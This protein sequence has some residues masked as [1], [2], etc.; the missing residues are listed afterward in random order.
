[1]GFKPWCKLS[2]LVLAGAALVGCNNGAQKDTKVLGATKGSPPVIG[3][4][5]NA[6]TG[7]FPI[8]PNN[9]SLTP[10]GGNAPFGRQNDPITIPPN[11]NSTIPTAPTGLPSIER[12]SSFAPLPGSSLSPN[13]GMGGLPLPGP[14][15]AG[16]PSIQLPTKDGWATGR[17][18]SPAPLPGGGQIA[19]IP[20]P[21][22]F[23]KR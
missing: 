8:A 18:T 12:P 22:D 14:S 11:P 1:M 23:L 5:P 4:L 13:G 6:N 16:A 15:G 3:A 10:I 9:N 7:P 17:E 21:N 19:P 2:V 20:M